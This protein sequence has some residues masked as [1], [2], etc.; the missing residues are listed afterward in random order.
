MHEHVKVTIANAVAMAF[1]HVAGTEV[2]P[3]SGPQPELSRRDSWLSSVDVADGALRVSLAFSA[4]LAADVAARMFCVPVGEVTDDD[5]EDAVG[6]LCSIVSGKVKVL[7]VP[8]GDMSLPD[9]SLDSGQDFRETDAQL[10]CDLPFC[11]GT[12]WLRLTLERDRY[13][14]VAA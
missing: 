3:L 13:A 6:E 4:D 2:V 5:I 14:E 12:S 10:L 8:G 9:V 1:E 7:A 11:V